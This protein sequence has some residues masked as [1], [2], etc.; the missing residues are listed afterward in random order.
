M[1]GFWMQPTA[2]AAAEAAMQYTDT[3]ENYISIYYHIYIQISVRFR[4]K[5]RQ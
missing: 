3:I 1:I 2:V 4:K 5:H